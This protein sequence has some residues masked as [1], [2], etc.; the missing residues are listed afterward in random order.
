MLNPFII[1]L[2]GTYYELLQQAAL[3][4]SLVKANIDQSVAHTRQV[5]PKSNVKKSHRL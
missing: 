2:D 5:H 3:T 1:E 4:S